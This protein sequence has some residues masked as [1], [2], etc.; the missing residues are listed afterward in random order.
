VAI[1]QW[2]IESRREAGWSDTEIAN[3]LKGASQIGSQAWMDTAYTGPE[4]DLATKAALSDAAY[5]NTWIGSYAQQLIDAGAPVQ[6]QVQQIAKTAIKPST[7]IE[8]LWSA[9]PAISPSGALATRIAES[10]GYAGWNANMGVVA[11]PPGEYNDPNAVLAPGS[12]VSGAGVGTLDVMQA[13]IDSLGSAIAKLGIGGG[14]SATGSDT[15]T[16]GGILS[17]IGMI[18]LLIIGGI[19]IGLIWLTMRGSRAGSGVPG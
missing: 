14:S 12:P 1:E 11:A 8:D 15:T 2:Q 9:V 16:G 4:P 7:A 18:P 5:A 10:G 13:E 19:F 3:W 17:Q 6:Q